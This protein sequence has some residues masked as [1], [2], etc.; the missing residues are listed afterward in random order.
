MRIGVLLITLLSGCSSILLQDGKD[1]KISLP[2]ISTRVSRANS[3]REVEELVKSV[4]D[5]GDRQEVNYLLSGLYLKANDASIR[6]KHQVASFF[7]KN[8]LELAPDNVDFK[9]NY[10]VELVR[11]KE[12]AK[13]EKLT[14]ELYIKTNDQ[15]VGFMLGGIYLAR[16]KLKEGLA[17]YKAIVKS[18]PKSENGCI[19]LANVFLMKSDLKM[20]ENLLNKCLL[21]IK[22]SAALYYHLGRVFAIKGSDK[23]AHKYFSK[24]LKV[25][26]NYYLSVVAKGLLYEKNGKVNKA[27]NLYKNTL[28]MQPQNHIVLQKLVQVMIDTKSPV[29]AISYMERLSILMP[30]NYEL[31]LNM[32]VVYMSQGRLDDSKD[33]LHDIL[34][35]NENFDRANFLLAS[36]Y[37]ELDDSER[38]IEFFHKVT[39]ES[40]LYI[41][42]Q[43][44]IAEILSFN[45]NSS[46]NSLEDKERFID[47]IQSA[48][49]EDD[50]KFGMSFILGKFYEEQG[51]LNKAI[52]LI[53]SIREYDEYSSKFDYYL[54]SLYEK[55]KQFAQSR[56]VI[57]ELLEKNPN[58]AHALNFVGYS[59]LEDG[60]SDYGKAIIYI[61]KA[62][63]LKP[64]DGYIRD[65]LGWYYYKIGDLKKALIEMKKAVSIVKDDPIINKHLAIIYESL[66]K[67][68]MAEKFYKKSLKYCKTLA[69]KQEIIKAL[70]NL[71][72]RSIASG[73]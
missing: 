27:I 14:K 17:I 4:K 34:L 71:K 28:K 70:E 46:T 39:R 65:S 69:E 23:S 21:N 3:K 10:I 40:S 55:N 63:S 72:N 13:A 33:I 42:T 41:R 36:V 6:G 22:D 35:A 50:L 30:Q 68:N 58:D 7:Y 25:D 38:A 43:V 20:A 52:E 37:Y 61:K 59:L 16:K 60:S 19:I 56:E 64:D 32:A 54:A 29:Q 48:I 66:K 45:A 12:L 53:L 18:N 31:K 24:S 73:E 15:N 2:D 9:K 47:F 11:S 62:I 8:I 44:R 51:E 67:Y 26:P 5:K 49:K 1:N 57:L